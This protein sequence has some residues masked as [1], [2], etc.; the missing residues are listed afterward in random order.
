MPRGSTSRATAASTGRSFANGSPMPMKTTFVI[1]RGV[2]G[3]RR[4]AA[5]RAHTTC[6]AISPAD[7]LFMRPICP[8]AQN[9]QFMAHPD[10]EDTHAVA[11][12]R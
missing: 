9:E 1:R 2:E 8:V 4:D 5:R 10:C 6:A 12:S 3:G 7:R 11:R